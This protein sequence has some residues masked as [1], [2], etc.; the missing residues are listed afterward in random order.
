MTVDAMASATDC[1]LGVNLYDIPTVVF[2]THP[3]DE[4]GTS[5]LGWSDA[6]GYCE[7]VPAIIASCKMLAR[8]ET[9]RLLAIYKRDY[10]VQRELVIDEIHTKSHDKLRIER[11]LAWFT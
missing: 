6:Y 2:I 10:K 1:V 3:Y 11:A 8:M 9:E 4:D 7:I 5:C